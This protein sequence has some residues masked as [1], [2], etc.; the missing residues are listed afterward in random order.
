MSTEEDPELRDLIAKSLENNGVLGK[1]RAQLRASTFLALDQQEDSKVTFPNSN[2]A[3]QEF[4]STKHGAIT[5]SLIR[6]FLT[7]FNLQFTLAVFDPETCESVSYKSMSRSDVASDLGLENISPEVP[8][9]HA[10]LTNFIKEQGSKAVL[11]TK[12]GK[13]TSASIDHVKDNLVNLKVSSDDY[14]EDFQ[15]SSESTPKNEIK[16]ASVEEELDVSASDLLASES[17]N[18]ADTMDKSA[19][20]S[21]LGV[22]DHVE[23]L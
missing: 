8:L 5:I 1:L 2:S 15:S 22:A 21:S 6:D 7:L 4:V 11:E 18:A 3:V 20:N 14:D 9:L 10:L 13:P 23:K 12:S 16:E 19:S 17:S